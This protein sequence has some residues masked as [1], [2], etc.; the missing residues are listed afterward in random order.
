MTTPSEIRCSGR[1]NGYD[2]GS[3]LHWGGQV[4][5]RGAR[6]PA[7]SELGERQRERRLPARTLTPFNCPCLI[8]ATA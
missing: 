8:R 1:R 3:R 6:G 7:W 4:A 5:H 2:L